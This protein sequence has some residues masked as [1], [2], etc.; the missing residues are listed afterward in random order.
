[1]SQKPTLR[2]WAWE[3]RQEILETGSGLNSIFMAVQKALPTLNHNGEDGWE[4]ISIV[5]LTDVS[6]ATTGL[7]Y[8]FKR[9]T[10]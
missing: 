3:Y 4:I 1:M 6:G 5:P 2:R 10:R 7:I 8:T 9:R